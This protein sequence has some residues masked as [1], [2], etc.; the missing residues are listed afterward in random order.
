MIYYDFIVGRYDKIVFLIWNT[1][2]RLVLFSHQVLMVLGKVQVKIGVGVWGAAE[3]V[4]S[5]T[6][7]P[8]GQLVFAA[9]C[10]GVFELADAALIFCRYI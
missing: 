6:H 1:Y 7:A 9:E 2:I 8:L 10:G 3:H 5:I 4:F